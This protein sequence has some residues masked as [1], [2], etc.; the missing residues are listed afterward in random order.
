VTAA[1]AL[2]GSLSLA[3]LPPFSGFAA[4]ALVLFAAASAR[5]WVPFAIAVAMSLVTAAYM[6][7]MSQRVFRGAA[8]DGLDRASVRE[9]P[10]SMRAAMLL[11]AAAMLLV[12]LAPQLVDALLAAP[13]AIT[14]GG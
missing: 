5:A 4:K 11:L 9:V 7:G 2:A 3:G 6:V 14:V 12:G 10:V 13:A 8:P 1:C